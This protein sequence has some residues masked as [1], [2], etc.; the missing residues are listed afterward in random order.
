[1]TRPKTSVERREEN[2]QAFYINGENASIE[3]RG[4]KGAAE[5]WLR[6][7]RTWMARESRAGRADVWGGFAM[8]CRL[9]LTAMQR[10]ADGD[11][12]IWDDLQQYAQTVTHQFPPK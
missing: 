9:F 11:S 2:R 6:I 8:V 10:R 12:R 1:M 7:T 4:D 3:S 5:S